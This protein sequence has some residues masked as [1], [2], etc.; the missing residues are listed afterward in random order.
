[1]DSIIAFIFARGGSKGVPGKNIRLLAGKPL[2]GWAIE[3]A[4]SVDCID[5]VIV[6]TDDP[7]IAEIAKDFDAAVPALR[8]KELATDTSPEWLSWQQSLRLFNSMNGYFPE[9]MVVLPTTAPLRKPVDI[10]RCVDLSF[11][12]DAD[13]VLT[14]TPAA[15]NP[16]YNMVVRRHDGSVALLAG[17]GGVASRQTAPTCYDM[18]TVAYVAKPAFV[19]NSTSMFT[20]DGRIEAVDI[21]Q[22]RALDIDTEL[23]F[24]IAEALFSENFQDVQNA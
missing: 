3:Q 18:T 10:V 11:T 4:R 9:R 23:D 14:V 19:L 7:V 8:P 22:E 5:Q 15:R 20:G 24:K 21:P 13:L 12:S 17:D 6:S 1:M 2:I 16:Y